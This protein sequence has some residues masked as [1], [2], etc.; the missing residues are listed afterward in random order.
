M[1]L[2]PRAQLGELLGD[3]GLGGVGQQSAHAAS[4]PLDRFQV[5]DVGAVGGVVARLGLEPG[6][7]DLGQLG[8]RG[9]AQA[10]REGVGV[11]PAPRA[12]GRGRVA[13]EGGANARDLVRGDRGSGA[14]PA[15]DDRLLGAA[16]GDVARGRLAGP[17]PVV[18]LLGRERSVADDLVPAP[19]EADLA[20][21]VRRYAIEA[22]RAIDCAGMARVDFLLSRRTGELV[23]GEIN[24]IPGFTTISM[25][26]RLWEAS[27]LAYPALLDR[28]IALALERHAE[29]RELGATR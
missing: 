13:A 1:R 10:E 11:V 9:G 14:G 20:E 25:Y 15:A 28:L 12:G 3:R 8:L 18:A 22:F 23:I 29:K 4:A 2:L 6:V 17:G 24:T 26:A 27:G 16:A 5:L 7:E 19:L 21:T